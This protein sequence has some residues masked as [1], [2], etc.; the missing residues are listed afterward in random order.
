V[1]LDHY[2]NHHSSHYQYYYY[3]YTT[4]TRER[5][6]E[7]NLDRDS[8]ILSKV[9]LFEKKVRSERI[10]RPT[11]ADRDKGLRP[12]EKRLGPCRRKAKVKAGL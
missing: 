9:S 3:H 12:R 6:R 5:E 4:T 7:K 10:P 1:P 2:A 11:P 8:P